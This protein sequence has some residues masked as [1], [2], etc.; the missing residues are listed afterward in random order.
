MPRSDLGRSSR[1]RLDAHR[2]YITILDIDYEMA[3]FDDNNDGQIFTRSFYLIK[4]K[5]NRTN[6]L[7]YYFFIEIFTKRISK[8]CLE[9]INNLRWSVFDK[10]VAEVTGIG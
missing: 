1:F 5:K 3:N 4:K 8:M 6:G 2:F 7:S 10:R 9:R